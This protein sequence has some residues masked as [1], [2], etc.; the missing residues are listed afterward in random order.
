MHNV[1][2]YAKG[3]AEIVLGNGGPVLI[4]QISSKSTRILVDIPSKMPSDL[5][6][7]MIDV[8]APQLPSN[9]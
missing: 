8:I 2:Q 5:K 3:H 6:Q 1:P 4:Y 9:S 7:H